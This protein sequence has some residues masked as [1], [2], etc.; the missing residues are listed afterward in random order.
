MGKSEVFI[1]LIAR[2]ARKFRT[3]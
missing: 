1:E 3:F 2:Q